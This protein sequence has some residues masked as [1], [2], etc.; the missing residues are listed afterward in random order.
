MTFDTI[1]ETKDWIY[2]N[3]DNYLIE[4]IRPEKNKCF[5]FFSSNGICDEES[6][7]QFYEDFYIKNRYEWRSIANTLKKKKDVSRII[8]I[9]DVYKNHYINGINES[10]N[11]IR[12]VIEL[13][14]EITEGYSVTYVGISSGGYMATI[15]GKTLGGERIFN[16]SGQYDVSHIAEIDNF[17]KNNSAYVSLV[18]LVNDGDKCPIFYFCPIGCG[19]D[20]ENYLR[21]KNLDNIWSFIFP[22]KIHA[23][24]VYPFNFPDLIYSSNEKIIRLS[25][26][27]DGK[28]INKK[29]FLLSTMT[30]SGWK[31]LIARMVKSR[32][33][34]RKLKEAWDVKKEIEG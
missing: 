14:K 29:R 27:Y 16:I 23:A 5:V 9:R 8:Y 10:Y 4:D 12:R 31:E 22:D 3:S 34:M 25:Q 2:A 18:E 13:L 17:M 30:I 32:F 15:L 1:L 7:E 26:K 19:H 11:N 24:T 28:L 6:A 33:N 20:R 21:I